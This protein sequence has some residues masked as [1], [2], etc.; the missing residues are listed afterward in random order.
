MTFPS[1][2]LPVDWWAL[3]PMIALSVGVML[4]LLLEFVPSARAICSCVKP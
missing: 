1:A 2:L 3:G 4:L